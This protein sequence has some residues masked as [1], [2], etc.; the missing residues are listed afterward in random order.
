MTHYD[1]REIPL[2]L[3]ACSRDVVTVLQ[4][5]RNSAQVAG[6]AYDVHVS[7]LYSTPADIRSGRHYDS[8]A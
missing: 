3:S 5:E 4:L 1:L 7:V 8:N 6:N 2:K